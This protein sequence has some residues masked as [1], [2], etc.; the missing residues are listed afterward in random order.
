[1]N[2]FEE[3]ERIVIATDKLVLFD[4]GVK[5]YPYNDWFRGQTFE[6]PRYHEL[7]SNLLAKVDK[8]HL[9]FK[10]LLIEPNTFLPSKVLQEL[11]KFERI[12]TYK[13]RDL[14]EAGKTSVT[15]HPDSER[16]EINKKLFSE[17]LIN[18]REMLRL[19]VSK[20]YIPQDQNVFRH[21]NSKVIN[22]S[23]TYDSKK[24]FRIYSDK[25]WKKDD[26]EDIFADE[27]LV[28]CAINCS[29]FENRP[30]RI[31]TLDG[32]IARLARDTVMD[33]QSPTNPSHKHYRACF[34]QFPFEVYFLST[35]AGIRCKF[36]SNDLESYAI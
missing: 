13:N 3:L 24:K 1:M 4:T 26:K 5:S 33:L 6:A 16:E 25:I 19:A 20:K 8:I 31:M 14:I 23:R 30:S 34:T 9:F 35:K 29:V 27:A 11:G 32:D 22:I 15:L 18:Y 36:E 2:I 7:D 21:I 10:G 28:A 12:L 17:L